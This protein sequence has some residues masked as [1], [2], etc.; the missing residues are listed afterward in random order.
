MLRVFPPP[1]TLVPV[2]AV[3][4][5]TTTPTTTTTTKRDM[6]IPPLRFAVVE[7]TEPNHHVLRSACPTARNASFLVRRRLRTVVSLVPRDV[8]DG[9]QMD[10]LK[11]FCAK[12]G[13]VHVFHACAEGKRALDSTSTES[14]AVSPSLVASVVSLCIDP[15]RM[16]VLVHCLDG[17]HVTGLV[18]GV[19]R[20]LQFWKDEH[21]MEEFR[22]FTKKHDVSEEE[23]QFV[24]SFRSPIT[25]P[26]S[27]PP[28]LWGGERPDK[29]PTM[30]LLATAV[31]APGA[32]VVDDD[33][34][35]D[36]APALIESLDSPTSAA[37]LMSFGASSS[38]A[39][40]GV[41]ASSSAVA[42]AKETG[43]AGDDDDDKAMDTDAAHPTPPRI[44]RHTSSTIPA[45]PSGEI[46]AFLGGVDWDGSSTGFV[47]GH[48]A[49]SVAVAV[50]VPSSNNAMSR[51]VKSLALEDFA[52][53]PPPSTAVSAVTAAPASTS[54]SLPHHPSS[55]PP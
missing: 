24:Q 46:L 15:A 36:A 4:S 11:A 29:H 17:G 32:V 20:R 49:V 12:E 41:G 31:S 9:S 35:G 40:A 8:W 33:A 14:P 7:A 37:P 39:S 50:A 52:F 5:T 1:A 44:F 28:W 30:K 10:E 6:V 23:K 2:A 27:L 18:V 43:T 19:L 38:S 48:A 13:V 34:G 55:A 22:R 47:G 21:I 53:P 26:A 45:R 51:V 3:T 42:A 25:L 16:P 54:N